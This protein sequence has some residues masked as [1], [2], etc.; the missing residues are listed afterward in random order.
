MSLAQRID[1]GLDDWVRKQKER[2]YVSKWGTYYPSEVPYCYR[3]IYFARH[4][5]KPPELS[6]LQRQVVGDI[7]HEHYVEP[8][9][10]EIFPNAKR[11]NSER[12]FTLTLD[13]KRKIF[14][15]GRADHYIHLREDDRTFMVEVKSVANLFASKHANLWAYEMQVMPCMVGLQTEEWCLLF[16]SRSVGS[17][18][19]YDFELDEDKLNEAIQRIVD[20]HGYH[21]RGEIPPPEGLINPV[22]QKTLKTRTKFWR[23]EYCSFPQECAALERALKTEED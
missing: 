5:S 1:D 15:R 11:L 16:M 14:I 3:Q 6:M 9:I 17:H 13:W 19:T 12:D 20:V 18:R 2:K 21:E 10:K 22:F 7:L 8:A 4:F 23:C